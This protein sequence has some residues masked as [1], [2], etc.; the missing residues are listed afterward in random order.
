VAT[1]LPGH[2]LLL[3]MAPFVEKSMYASVTPP[4][5]FH[6]SG[7][8]LSVHAFGAFVVVS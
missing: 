1:T 2:A 5:W 8:S 4:R 3:T 6:S 7:A